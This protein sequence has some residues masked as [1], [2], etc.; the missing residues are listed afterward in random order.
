VDDTLLMMNLS[1]DYDIYLT[2]SSRLEIL[3][4]IGQEG[5][6]VAGLGQDCWELRKDAYRALAK[7]YDA[8]G[9]EG[10]IRFWAEKFGWSFEQLSKQ[11]LRTWLCKDDAA[12]LADPSKPGGPADYSD[13]SPVHSE[14]VKNLMRSNF[15]E[16]ALDWVDRAHWTGPVNIPW[17][18]IDKDDIDGWA[19]SHQQDAVNRFARDIKANRGH[20]NPSILIQDNDSP[21]AIIIDGHHRALARHKLGQPVLS[22]L[23]NIEPADRQAAEETHS[24]QVHS[25]ASPENR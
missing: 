8:N 25:G 1:R 6:E 4:F 15:P 11:S 16:D 23:G 18:R 2:K 12:D 7:I 5:A 9:D 20:T 19:A 21:K 14:H 22:Y 13:P 3:Q 24:K 10:F 17:E